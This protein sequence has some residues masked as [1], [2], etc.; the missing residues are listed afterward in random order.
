[1]DKIKLKSLRRIFLDYSVSLFVFMLL[2]FIMAVQIDSFVQSRGIYRCE[3]DNGVLLI[4]LILMTI[5]I[6]YQSWH[7][8][9]M[10]SAEMQQLTDQVI[11]IQQER[12]DAKA[13]H[14]RIREI[15]LTLGVFEQLKS[16]LADSLEKQ[17]RMEEQKKECILA[18][19]HDMKTPIAILK[20]NSELLTESGL[21]ELQCVYNES[22]LYNIDRMQQYTEAII[23]VFKSD[24][25]GEITRKS[26]DFDAFAQQLMQNY[27]LL[28][29]QSGRRLESEIHSCGMYD[30]DAS[31]LERAINNIIMNALEY[32]PEQGTVKIRLYRNDAIHIIVED[33][34]SGF[35]DDMLEHATEAF[36]RGDKSRTKSRDTLHIGLG[37]YQA[38]QAIEAHGGELVIANSETFSGASIEIILR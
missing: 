21:N 19:G 6:I 22:N 20:G 3:S 17:W 37:L 23:Q 10:I 26:Q 1:M 29:E 36:V 15:E 24:N 4:F 2:C 28:A 34:G 27:Q 16:E 32:S 14:S 7:Y 9:R 33:S 25:R 11:N 12:L 5:V 38:R 13:G 18:L 30:F 8:G 31:M 35:S